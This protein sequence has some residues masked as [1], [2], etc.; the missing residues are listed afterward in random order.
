MSDAKRKWHCPHCSQDSSR[1]WNLKVHIK[2]QHSGIGEPIDNYEAKEFNDRRGY[3]FF[4]HNHPYGMNDLSPGSRQGKEKEQDIIDETYQIVI[5]QKETLRKIKEIK[6]FFQ[7]LSSLSFSS[8]QQ[9]NIIT[10]L[11]QTPS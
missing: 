3:Q 1:H 7:E 6:S 9:P 4:S 5:K 2:K 8:F 10:S 11:E